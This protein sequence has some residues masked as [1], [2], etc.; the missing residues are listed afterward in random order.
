MEK[1]TRK[2]Y[3]YE[4]PVFCYGREHHHHWMAETTAPSKA[5]ARSNLAYRYKKE[6]G[7]VPTAKV[8]F[9][10]NLRCVGS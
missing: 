10:D 6:F 5:K 1:D 9:T 4:G 8:T 7:L 2:V 3:T